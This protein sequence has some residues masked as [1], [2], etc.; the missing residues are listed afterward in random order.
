MPWQDNSGNG[1]GPWGQPPRGG[2]NGPR[3]PGG[4]PDLEELLRQGQRRFRRAFPGGGR[5]GGGMSKGALAL[6]GAAGVALYIFSGFYQVDTTELAA[7]SRFGK[8]D[9]VAGPGLK[10]HIPWPV[11][12][13][14]TER[15]DELREVAVA[16]G[17]S[18]RSDAGLMLTGD[19]NF[20]NI[21]FVIQYNIKPSRIALEGDDL[22]PVAQFVYNIDD[23]IQL[24]RTVAESSMREVVG[25]L[26]L[27]PIITTERRAV[28]D[29]TQRLMQEALDA[30]DSGIEIVNLNIRD[31]VPPAQ[32][33]DAF[34][35]V[36]NADQDRQTRENEATRYAN[37]VLPQARGEAA[38]LIQEAEAYSARVVAEARGEAQRFV[39]IYAE[40][41]L[42]PEVTRR[43][44]YLETVESVLGDMNKIVIDQD[45]QSGVV[46]Y[47]PLN[48]LG[49][50]RGSPN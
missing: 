24:V 44:M 41:A 6:L 21:D 23:P 31:A 9:R 42:A 36:E 7:V 2:G 50:R 20:V 49:R 15:V 11:E 17:P 39:S 47:L 37:E 45:G 12:S 26:S 38:K 22:P 28:Q 8:F 19:K 33:I 3:R 48:E 27:E 5:G 32:V 13:A 10:W 25:R 46:P 29:D 18:A 34:R 30:Y 1:S 16:G 40:Y 14:R 35:D 4:Q 43:R